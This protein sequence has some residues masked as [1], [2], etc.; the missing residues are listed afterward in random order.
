MPVNKR[1]CE[2]LMYR[3]TIHLAAAPDVKTPEGNERAR[4]VAEILLTAESDAQADAIVQRLL[5]TEEFFP[6]VKRVC[7]AA[8]AVRLLEDARVRATRIQTCLRCFEADCRCNPC[9]A[10]KGN[11]LRWQEEAF[12]FTR[13]ACAAGEKTTD[14][15]LT[16]WNRQFARRTEEPST[17]TPRRV[18]E[19]CGQV[20]CTCILCERCQDEGLVRVN[21]C[22]ERCECPLARGWTDSAIAKRNREQ[23]KSVL[24]PLAPVPQGVLG[25]RAIVTLDQLRAAKGKRG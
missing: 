3:L 21:N 19:G 9:P 13:C 17:K 12:A 24:S 20:K 11:G 18:C 22:Y 7:D 4:G 2:Q 8:L 23:A 14:A 25:K 15:V 16:G 1:H 10:C 5:E 6:T